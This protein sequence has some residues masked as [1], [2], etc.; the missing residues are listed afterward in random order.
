[1]SFTFGGFGG[2]GLLF[3]VGK[4]DGHS[5]SWKRKSPQ[6]RSWLLLLHRR[7]PAGRIIKN[8]EP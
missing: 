6:A 3:P 7:R 4:T 1:M 2:G 8:Y 5:D